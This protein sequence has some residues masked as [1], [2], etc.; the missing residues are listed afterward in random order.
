MSSAN[1]V[2]YVTEYLTNFFSEASE[3]QIKS[4]VENTDPALVQVLHT[5]VNHDNSFQEILATTIK[6]IETLENELSIKTE[7]VKDLELLLSTKVKVAPVRVKKEERSDFIRIEKVK[8]LKS[9]TYNAKLF[10]ICQEI[11]KRF[12]EDNRAVSL[13]EVHRHF[14]Q[15]RIITSF[16]QSTKTSNQ[17][18]ISKLLHELFII[19]NQNNEIM[20]TPTAL[21]ITV[22]QSS[23]IYYSQTS[24]QKR[25]NTMVQSNQLTDS[26]KKL[27][28]VICESNIPF[29]NDSADK[30]RLSTFCG[31]HKDNISKYL[32]QMVKLGFL[33]RLPDEYSNNKFSYQCFN[34]AIATE[35]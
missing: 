30:T 31:I 15:D 12:L 8:F 11:F 29:T 34:Q 24:V 13:K 19:E 22:Y 10:P 14:G 18:A 9:A 1:T 7:K 23:L 20:I 6:K 21:G 4:V 28:K 2:Q 3:D 32:V 35:L 33:I 17:S 26:K 25:F 27:L 5:L 16:K